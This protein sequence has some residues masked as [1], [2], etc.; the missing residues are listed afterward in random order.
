M[1]IQVTEKEA[2][3]AVMIVHGICQDVFK[4]GIAHEIRLGP[5]SC[6]ELYD[7]HMN[8]IGSLDD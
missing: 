1:D 3:E 5:E 2:K 6:K 4:Y 8:F 7:W